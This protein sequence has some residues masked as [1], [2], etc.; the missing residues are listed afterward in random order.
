[1]FPHFILPVAI[2]SWLFA[3]CMRCV[4][5]VNF[6]HLQLVS[7]HEHLETDI[8]VYLDKSIA[9]NCWGLCTCVGT[10]ISNDNNKSNNTTT[11]SLNVCIPCFTNHHYCVVLWSSV[12]HIGGWNCPQFMHKSKIY[13]NTSLLKLGQLSYIIE[14]FVHLSQW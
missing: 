4:T 1:M 6:V 9:Q 14:E 7:H 5:C 13:L 10:K 11:T 3:Q 12:H 8:E 2:V